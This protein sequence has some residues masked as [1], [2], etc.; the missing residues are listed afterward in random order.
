MLK[1]LPYHSFLADVSLTSS[2][3]V[4]N[5]NARMPPTSSGGAG[6][7]VNTRARALVCVCVCVCVCLR[8]HTRAGAVSSAPQHAS[9]W[10]EQAVGAR[11]RRAQ[12]P[13][14]N[15]QNCERS[16]T[17]ACGGPLEISMGCEKTRQTFGCCYSC[18]QRERELRGVVRSPG[19][20]GFR[21]TLMSKG[22]GADLPRRMTP[23]SISEGVG[24]GAI[25]PRLRMSTSTAVSAG[26]EAQ[27]SE[28]LLHPM[29][30]PAATRG[31]AL[32]WRRRAQGT[33]H[34]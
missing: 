11:N 8:A 29:S 6:R 17:G 31:T 10:R 22:R 1:G 12:D 7:T 20:G 27:A 28:L 14:R 18:V 9:C 26:R 30:C 5:Q 33:W 16:A 21:R 3:K 2:C 4:S 24:G 25:N 32:S 15:Q 19:E 34:R 23:R 13:L